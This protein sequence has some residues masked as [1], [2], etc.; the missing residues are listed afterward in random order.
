MNMRKIKDMMGDDG[1]VG[2]QGIYPK[3]QVDELMEG[4][5]GRMLILNHWN[6]YGNYPNIIVEGGK[7]K[8]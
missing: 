6:Q 3:P 4:A 2:L 1:I 7:V 5:H 8:S